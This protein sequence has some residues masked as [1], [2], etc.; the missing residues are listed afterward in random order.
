MIGS[1]HEVFP[2]NICVYFNT[3][4]GLFRH[5]KYAILHEWFVG[6]CEIPPPLDLIGVIW[7]F[8]DDEIPHSG[9]NMC[10]CCHSDWRCD[11]VRCKRYI[12]EI[13]QI[14]NF[15]CLKYSTLFQTHRHEAY[16]KLVSGSVLGSRRVGTGT[17][18]YRSE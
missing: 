3:Q 5:H 4:S 8:H 6:N 2:R 1:G 17:H 7:E 13:R 14:R 16:H 18:R 11:V 9:T 15:L 10:C 12:V